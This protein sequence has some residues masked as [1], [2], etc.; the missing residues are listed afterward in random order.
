VVH[1]HVVATLKSK[2]GNSFFD[3][4]ISSKEIQINA[5][6]KRLEDDSGARGGPERYLD[7]LDL[8][9]IIEQ[10]DNWPFFESIFNIPLPKQKKGIAKYILWFEEVNRIRRVSA[11]PFER[12][13]SQ[14]D[15]E[16][17][18]LVAAQLARAG[19]GNPPQARN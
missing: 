3:E 13:Y 12:A 18:Q 4:G 15:L 2:Y 9:K 11:H 17:L 14:A 7:F 19:L 16:I 5:H 10:K 6:K 8:R 1:K